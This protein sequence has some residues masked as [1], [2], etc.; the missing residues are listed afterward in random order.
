MKNLLFIFSLCSFVSFGQQKVFQRDVFDANH[1]TEKVG[2]ALYPN[3]ALLNSK[4]KTGVSLSDV[5]TRKLSYDFLKFCRDRIIKFTDFKG[6][7]F[8]PCEVLF[9]KS[10][11]I[12][13]LVY[14]FKKGT[15]RYT[16]FKFDS[17]TTE[18]T[19]IF[20]KVAE[21]FCK[22]YSLKQKSHDGNFSLN[23]SINF[24]KEARKLRKNTISSIEM[25]ENCDK[26]DT[27]K[28]LMLNKLYLEAFPE[29][30]FKFK[31]LEKLDLSD[32]YIEQIPS[33]IWEL[34]KLK[35]LSLSG[36][37]IDYSNF[38]FK[39]N[40]HLKDLNLQFTGMT[41]MPKSTKK[42]R[43]LEILFVGNNKI[44]LRK[45]D[46]RRMSNLKALNLYNIRTTYLPKSI[47]KLKNLTELDLYY[48]ELQNLPKE[49]CQLENLQTLA[50]SNNNLW[51]LP[52]EI[53]QMTNL[54]TLYAHHNRL[55]NLPALPNLKLLDIGYNAFK[56]FPEQVYELTDLEEFDIT[57][58][59]VNEVPEKLLALKKLQKVYFRGNEFMKIN[60][61][62]KDVSRLVA[63]LEQRNILVR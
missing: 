23:L 19:A 55:N 43:N 7:K 40:K 1:K 48:N 12:D 15:I 51:D 57:N 8:F 42:N 61:K 9:D 39:K 25:A 28:S 59:Q 41:K 49:I 18:E 11:K 27:V 38:K 36:N 29:I 50:V 53:S 45:N 10:G 5:D 52:K 17:L 26:P 46:F 35:Q 22:N 32:N 47:G 6:P 3:L 54:Q 33:Q 58:N 30:V 56:V 13:Y 21:E 60:E 14:G 44:E 16:T 63:D 20:T 2:I 24:G 37:Y 4:T 62:S 34:K 31:N